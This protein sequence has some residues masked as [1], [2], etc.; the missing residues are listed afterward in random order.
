MTSPMK[1]KV[2]IVTGGAGSVGV[3]GARRLLEAGAQ[4]L[5]VDRDSTL[6]A[7]AKQLLAD[8]EARVA[9]I[10]ADV[11]VEQD[12]AAFVQEALRR[13]GRMD[14][15][16]CNAGINGDIRSIEKY[17]PEVFDHV[18]AVNVRGPFLACKY[19]LPAL[20][21]GGSIIITSSVMGVTADPGICAYATSKHAVIGLMRVAAKEGAR[22]RIRVNVLAPGP[23]DNEFQA[24]VERRLSKVVGTNATDMLNDKIPLGRHGRVDEI[25]DMMLFLASDASSFSTGGVFMADG[26][27]SI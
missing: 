22:R 21:D 26:G 10:V 13:F 14:I 8:F 16:I 18:M 27:M 3:A 17:D 19:G 4:V 23:I 2:A 9:T 5:I 6:L 1:G 20:Q 12:N 15:L 24:D 11:S 7:Q 25:A